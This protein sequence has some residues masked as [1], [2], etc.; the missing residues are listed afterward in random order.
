MTNTF[1]TRLSAQ[2][3]AAR[4]PAPHGHGAGRAGLAVDANVVLE[5]ARIEHEERRHERALAV[6]DPPR[7]DY[8]RHVRAQR[9]LVPVRAAGVAPEERADDGVAVVLGEDPQAAP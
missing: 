9:L 6:D 3:P 7:P 4:S 1:P 5:E 2:L 8:G